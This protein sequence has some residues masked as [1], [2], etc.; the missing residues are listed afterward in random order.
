MSCGQTGGKTAAQMAGADGATSHNPASIS[1]DHSEDVRFQSRRSRKRCK[2][3]FTQI[4]FK[5]FMGEI[6]A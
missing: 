5:L 1:K 3:P 6:V 4:C 2:E